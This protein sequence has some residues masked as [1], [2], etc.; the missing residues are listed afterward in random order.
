MIDSSF[1]GTWFLPDEQSASGQRV[2]D[3]YE[4][5]RLAFDVPDLLAYEIPNLF[6]SALRRKRFDSD[7]F[8]EAG[9]IFDRIEFEYHN[10]TD[11]VCRRRMLHF[12]ERHQLTA[13]DAAYLELADR[14][15]L[16]LLTLDEKLLR[17]AR[18]E[19]LETTVKLHK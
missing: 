2:F 16:P 18:A 8:H 7:G 9:G 13:Y 4:A 11:A 19:N 1:V 5:G 10:Q 14:L 17:A 6:V 12:A 15:Q 3:A